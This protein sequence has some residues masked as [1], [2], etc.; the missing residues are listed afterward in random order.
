M[1]QTLGELESIT[2]KYFEEGSVHSALNGIQPVF[3]ILGY[4]DLR[5]LEGKLLTLADA[6]FFDSQQRKAFKDLI[7]QTIWWQWVPS[8]DHGPNPTSHGMPA[9]D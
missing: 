1:S 5:T 7:R 4:E 3:A 9:R 6:S 2:K 8:L